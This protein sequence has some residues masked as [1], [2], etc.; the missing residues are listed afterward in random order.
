MP[1]AASRCFLRWCNVLEGDVLLP[2]PSWVSYAPH[3]RLAGRRITLVETDQRDHHRITPGALDDA[4]AR[5]RREGADPRMLVVNTP[6]NPTGGM[7][8]REDVEAIAMLV[9]RAGHHHHQRRNLR[10]TGAR[11]ARACLAR[12]ILPEGC[13]VTG[14]LSKAFSAGGWRLGYAAIPPGEVGNRLMASLQALASEIWSSAS[15][16]VQQA[17]VTAYSAHPD[18]TTYVQSCARLHGYTTAR[19]YETLSRLGLACPRPAGGFYL[20]PDF[21]PFREV[22]RR[23]G[24]TTGEQLARC[25]LR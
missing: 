18:L 2:T 3:A 8:A 1:L 23:R 15:T 25:L 17:A 20:Y 11:L 7:F 9:A 16:P 19:L 10:G 21:A 14:G 13:I 6:S 4:L 22:L 5:A 24:I 12:A